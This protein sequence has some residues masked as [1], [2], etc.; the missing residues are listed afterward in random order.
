MIRLLIRRLAW[1]LP[2]V[3]GVLTLVFFLIHLIPGD[4]VDLMLGEQ[5][6]SADR[7]TLKRA[8]HLDEPIPAQ[9]RRFLSGI[10]RGDL[11]RSLR[12]GRP[13]AEMIL[14][15]YPATLQLA[16]TAL[17]IALLIAI[18]IGVYSAVRPQSRADQGALLLSLLGVSIPNF[19]LGPLLILLFS[20]RLDWFPV[21]GRE[22]PAA[23]V[24][25]ALTLAIGMSA[26]LIRMTRAS[27][28]EVVRKEYVVA[29]RAKGLSERAVI[30][31]HAFPNALVPLLTVVGL[32][33]GALLTGSIITETIFSWPGL[34]RLTLQAIQSRDYPLV[35]GCILAISL[36]YLFAN[37]LVD[38]L[39]AAADPRVRLIRE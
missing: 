30:L 5:A 6:A 39:Y 26:L 23:S 32:Q 38:L 14:A 2:V 33:F 16:F 24:L 17:S 12:T 4:P 31:K 3:L 35:Q 34:G 8:L 27:L 10:A 9:Y 25:P 18:P 29:A 1:T 22:G 15:R 21:S 37:L 19:W 20:I 7:E 13:V 28:L 11:G 36:T